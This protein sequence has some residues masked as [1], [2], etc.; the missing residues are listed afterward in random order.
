MY[1]SLH[2][3]KFKQTNMPLRAGI[4]D[5]NEWRGAVTQ[6]L[7][8]SLFAYQ[9]SDLDAGICRGRNISLK[10]DPMYTGR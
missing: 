7:P 5:G 4:G 1:L 8:I 10:L 6:D 3:I 9:S 2:D